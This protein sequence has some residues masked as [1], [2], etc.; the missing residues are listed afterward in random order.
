MGFWAKYLH[1]KPFVHQGQNPYLKKTRKQTNKKKT[2]KRNQTPTFGKGLSCWDKGCMLLAW[3]SQKE[4]M[5]TPTTITELR[6]RK[7]FLHSNSQQPWES[8]YPPSVIFNKVFMD[9]L[10]C[11]YHWYKNATKKKPTGH[12][13]IL[14][15]QLQTH[16]YNLNIKYNG[17]TSGTIMSSENQHL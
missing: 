5:T 3:A 13:H 2:N 11:L 14:D 17:L 10:L 4:R 7:I 6:E 8:Q 15:C 16:N 1:S 9:W 12:L